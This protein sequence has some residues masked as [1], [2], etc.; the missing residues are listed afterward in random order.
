MEQLTKTPDVVRTRATLAEHQA[1]LLT[2][3]EEFDRIC[4]KNG[5]RYMLFAGS[6][7]GAVRHGGFIPWDDDL[8]ILM[9]RP[10]YERFLRLAPDELPERFFLQ[11]EY[12][13]HWPMPFSKLRLNGTACIERYIPRDP[14]THQGVYIDL[15]PCDELSDRSFVG[16]IQ[17]LASRVVIAKCLRRRGYLTDSRKKKIFMAACTCLPAAPFRRLAQHRRRGNTRMVHSFFGA[18]AKYEKATYPRAYIE[19]TIEADFAGGRYPISAHADELLTILYGDWRTPLPPEKR[20]C[21]VHAEL[22][23]LGTDWR[24][25]EGIQKTMQFSEYTRSIR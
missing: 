1:A 21:K 11:A 6:A 22:V 2:L 9:L 23:D 19:E 17:Y 25:Y 15:F 3:L 24:E 14:E 8:D 20:G 5:I 4:R 10:E 16:H 13:P 18:S 12:S 7:L